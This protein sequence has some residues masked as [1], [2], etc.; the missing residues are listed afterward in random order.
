M[1]RAK[2]AMYLVVF[3]SGVFMGSNAKAQV[4]DP[5]FENWDSLDNGFFK[6]YLPA[7]WGDMM[8]MLCEMESKPWAVTRTDDARTGSYAIQLKN[9]A[10]SSPAGPAILSTRSGRPEEFNN[11]IPV[12][13]RHAKVEGY[14]KYST[15]ATDTFTISVILMKGESFIG[16]GEYKQFRQAD[17]YTK[18]TVP[19]MYMA[20]ASVI[21]DSAVIMIVAGSE[22]HFTE[23]TTLILDDVDFEM[24]SGINEKTELKAE[25]S[26]WPNPAA[27]PAN[28]NINGELKGQVRID[29]TDL[30]GK[31]IRT[32]SLEGNTTRTQTNIMLADLPSGILFVK[33]SD[34]NGTKA[35]RL[36]NQ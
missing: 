7:G 17:A 30:L 34:D 4:S 19:V 26:V 12:N 31:T 36:V 9:I 32:I 33:V 28:L 23:G 2:R 10:L 18:F 3:I 1:T 14:Y 16:F 21:P 11:K 5:G 35:L 29:V 13:K 22:E 25:I 24:Q 6:N 15:P 27:G 20:P 8:N